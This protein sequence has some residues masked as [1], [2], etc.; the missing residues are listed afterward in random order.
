MKACYVPRTLNV[1]VVYAMII[2]YM[3]GALAAR[4]QIALLLS[5]ILMEDVMG[6]RVR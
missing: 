5:S 4:I 1:Q 3:E 2:R 6:Y